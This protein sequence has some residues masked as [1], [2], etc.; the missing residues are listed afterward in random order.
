MPDHFHGLIRLDG[1]RPL[2]KVVQHLKSSASRECRM[3]Q[4][5]IRVWARA[6]HDHALRAEE[7]IRVAAR[8]LVANPIRAGLVAHAYDYP[9]WDAMWLNPEAPA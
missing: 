7:D 5:G 4:P 1:V 9:Y 8:Y 2:S 3:R 6:F